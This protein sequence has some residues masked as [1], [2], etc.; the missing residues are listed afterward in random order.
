MNLGWKSRLDVALGT[1]RRVILH[2]N[3]L[4]DVLGEDDRRIDMIEWLT[5]ALAARGYVRIV[6]YDLNEPPRALRWDG[7]S[8]DIWRVT[9]T[10]ETHHR[11]QDRVL[12]QLRRYLAVPDVP[13]ALILMCADIGVSYPSRAAVALHNVVADAALVPP[14]ES[15]AAAPGAESGDRNRHSQDHTPGPLRNLAVCVYSRETAIPP[16]FVTTDPDTRLILVAPPSFEERVRYFRTNQSEFH[17][18]EPD[19]SAFDPAELARRTEGF[20]LKELGQL[21][22]LSR[23]ECI[24]LDNLALLLTM[25]TFGRDEDRWAHVDIA[26]MA[27]S[28]ADKGIRGQEHAVRQVVESLRRAKHRVDQLVDPGARKPAAVCFFVGPTGVGKTMVG[29]AL[30][31]HLTGSPDSCLII[32]M[33]EYRQDHSDQKLIGSPPGYVGFEQGGLL[34]RWVKSRPF[35]VV[36]I[37]EVEKAHNGIHD[38]FLQIFDGA[39]L[40]DGKG[41][42]VDFSQTVLVFTSNI[43]TDA[44]SDSLDR[45][46]YSAVSEF[47]TRQ[48]EGF[49]SGRLE[50]PELFNRLKKGVIVFGFIREEAARDVITGKLRGLTD[51]TNARLASAGTAARLAFD[52]VRDKKAV[53]RLLEL[54]NYRTYGLRDVNNVF[55]ALVGTGVARMLDDPPASGTWRF[56]WDQADE[57]FRPM[58]ADQ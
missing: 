42:T 43:G 13:S 29:R 21:A 15:P 38:L 24:G 14:R 18:T 26:R 30:A 41:E 56:E 12:D 28:I 9:G 7:G 5:N 4:D 19:R 25:F 50:R 20:R 58:R 46:N 47:F 16:E 55:S 22:E 34:T 10:A 35:S 36:I 45:T 53:D 51:G 3:V 11:D 40:T 8:G 52:P 54:T 39:R 6:A 49:F 17:L 37:D 31:E 27:T 48:V 2:G 32:D 33:S 1:K 44:A 23:R 57:R